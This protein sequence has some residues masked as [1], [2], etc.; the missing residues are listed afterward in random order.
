M[1]GNQSVRDEVPNNHCRSV[2]DR[3][4][5][6]LT[7]HIKCSVNDVNTYTDRHPP[8]VTGTMTYTCRHRE[9]RTV[10]NFKLAF[11]AA[12]REHWHNKLWI[13][14]SLPDP[15]VPPLQCGVEVTF[16]NSGQNPHCRITMLYE[17][18]PAPNQRPINFRS[19]CYHGGHSN[20][21]EEDMAIAYNLTGCGRSD[22]FDWTGARA[23]VN[24]TAE[25]DRTGDLDRLLNDRIPASGDRFAVASFTQ[26]LAAHEFGHYLGLNHH[27]FAS[28]H[29]NQPA[30]YCHQGDAEMVDNMMAAGNR[31]TALHGEPWVSR[32][33]LHHYHCDRT[34]RPSTDAIRHHPGLID[35]LA[36]AP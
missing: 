5:N 36:G 17:P 7:L 35:S 33:R 29:A 15:N 28:A 16:V 6:T 11:A 13:Y 8:G 23:I 21:H 14:P 31:I 3:A 30:D 24:D 34:W 12:I 4:A 20:A 2:L 26:N 27:C 32:L 18:E 1:C 9:S 19:F 10:E 25:V 22:D